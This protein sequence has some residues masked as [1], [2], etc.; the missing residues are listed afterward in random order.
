[1]KLLITGCHGLVGTN[2][3]PALSSHFDIVPLDIE[4]WDITDRNAGEYILLNHKPQFIINLA[5]MTDVDGCEDR[6]EMA[7]KINSDGPATVAEL[8][9]MFHIPLIHFST[10]YVFDGEKAFPYTEEDMPHPM[11]V[12][13]AT[14]LSGERRIQEI[15]P[16]SIIIRAQWIYGHGGDNF[17]SKVTRIAQETG[18]ARVVNDQWGAPTYARDL[19]EPIRRLVETGKP[20]IYH[21]ANSGSCSWYE[22]TKEIFS[23]LNIDV[24]LAPIP[25]SLLDRKAKRPRYAVFDCSK[26]QREIG[27]TMRT[28]QEA[29]QEYIG[30]Q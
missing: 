30:N 12:Y 15:H 14:K 18:A 10:D 3:I 27:V 7:Q 5:A 11:S 2:I 6:Q 17:I 21:I 19:A 25:S 1:M 16:L 29:L 20:G 13:G 23:C 26:I 28:W 22:F 9:K 24:P 8:C 4:E